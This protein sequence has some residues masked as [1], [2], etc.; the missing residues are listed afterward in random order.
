MIQVGAAFLFGLIIGF[1]A[2]ALVYRRHEAEIESAV[3][4]GKADIAKVQTAATTLKNDV[5]SIGK[6]L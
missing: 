1:I 3:A 4:T 5:T 2:G 6:K